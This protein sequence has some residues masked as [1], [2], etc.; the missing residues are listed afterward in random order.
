M[1]KFKQMHE[2]PRAQ[3]AAHP[4]EWALEFQRVLAMYPSEYWKLKIDN[5]HTTFLVIIATRL[6][7]WRDRL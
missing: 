6:D 2:Y 1:V 5:S 4:A 3:I 7:S